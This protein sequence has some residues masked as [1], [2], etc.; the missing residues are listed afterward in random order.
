MEKKQNNDLQSILRET[1][2]RR[3]KNNKRSLIEKNDLKKTKKIKT[4]RFIRN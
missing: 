1:A 4:A 2:N 3:K